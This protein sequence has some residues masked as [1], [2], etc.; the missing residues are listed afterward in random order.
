MN[1]KID[2][3]RFHPKRYRIN[4]FLSKALS[5]MSNFAYIIVNSAL[6]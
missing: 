5:H 4:L 6:F 3:I 2:F 1:V